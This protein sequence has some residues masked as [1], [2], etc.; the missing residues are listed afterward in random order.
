MINK[1]ILLRIISFIILF[2]LY[3]YSSGIILKYIHV[4]PIVVILVFPIAFFIGVCLFIIY[5][6]Y[7]NMITKK[8]K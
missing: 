2:V 7:H 5:D 1:N 6:F 8:K 3:V 4:Y